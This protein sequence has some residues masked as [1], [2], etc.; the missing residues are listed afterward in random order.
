MITL[1]RITVA[2]LEIDKE[3]M[4]KRATE[5]FSTAT[6]LA[7][8]LVREEGLP[9]RTSH[10]IVGNVV[11]TALKQGLRANAITAEMVKN[12]AAEVSG[13][14]VTLTPEQVARALDPVQNLAEKKASGSP[15][16]PETERLID[17]AVASLDR[18]HE[19]SDRWRQRQQ[20]AAEELARAAAELT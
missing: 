11:A 7:D 12:A 8:L 17:I 15:S 14:P 9:F 1:T 4:L 13:E 2:G 16:T 3:L 20:Q 10:S 18:H 5:D 6:E 19:A